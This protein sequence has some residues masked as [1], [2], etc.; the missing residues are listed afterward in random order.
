MTTP[1]TEPPDDQPQVKL[2]QNAVITGIA[3]AFVRISGLLREIVFAGM[4]GAG[5]AA[6]AYN[7]AMR[8]AQFLRELLA[9]GSLANAYVPIFAETAEEKGIKEAWKLANAFL[10]LLLLVLGAVTLLILLFAD[11]FIIIF[12]AGFESDPGVLSVVGSEPIPK[13]EVATS[14]ARWLAPLMAT[15]SLASLFMGML[16]VR[17]KFFLPSVAPAA[18]NVAVIIGCVFGPAFENATGEPAITLVAIASVIGGAGQFLVQMPALAR[19]GFYARPHLKGHPALKRMVQFL[20]PAFIAVMTVQFG[21]LVETQ[22]ASRMGTGPVS[23][24]LYA[25]RIVLLPNSVVA[26][27]VATAA[28]AGLSLLVAQ[29]RLKEVRH[30]LGEAITLNNFVMFP[31]TV[32]MF[33]LAEPLVRLFY[34]RGAFLPSTTENVLCALAVY[35]MGAWGFSFHRIAIP[36]FYALKDPWF[37]MKVGIAVMVAKV[38]VALFFVYQWEL[39]FPGLG[40]M[41]VG[42]D[43]GWIGLPV[44]QTVLVT[45][46]AI[47]LWIG[48]K[49]LTERMRPGLVRDHLKITAATLGMYGALVVTKDYAD[50]LMLLVVVTAVSAIYLLISHLL[51]LPY[52]STIVARLG[53][54]VGVKPPGG[55]GLPPFVDDD[56]RNALENLSTSALKTL[57]LDDG[58]LTIGTNRGQV[59]VFSNENRLA[60]VWSEQEGEQD[61][62]EATALVIKAT[63]RLGQGPPGLG[64][65]TIGDEDFRATPNGI[66]A[67]KADGPTV[68]IGK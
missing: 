56:T 13:F 47:V 65:I 32:A 61:T 19:E 17:G 62:T 22:I 52:S 60:C 31:A 14:L 27:A 2:G 63:L 10:G 24:L 49:R 26:S 1:P 4:F 59:R 33:V 34:E 12:A 3:V 15:V 66:E 23:Y 35:A 16:N 38:P 43:W 5:V 6:D 9:E 44:S 11:T 39:E 45:L 54:L 21:I 20:I 48:L 36:C 55:S 67:G 40:P 53:K 68:T 30:T 7:A 50:G 58:V 57:D 18:F 37:P 51:G 64:G 46:E 41:L 25:M 8:A 28:L 29:S 42:L